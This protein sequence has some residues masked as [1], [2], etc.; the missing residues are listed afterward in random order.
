MHGRYIADSGQIVL[1]AGVLKLERTAPWSCLANLQ[2]A[3]RDISN[4]NVLFTNVL[5]SPYTGYEI[6]IA[7]SGIVRVK[8]MHEFFA[9]QTYIEVDGAIFV[10]DGNPHMVAA[11]YDGSSTAAGVKIYVDG[12]PDTVVTVNKDTLNSTIVTG[13]SDM[14]LCNQSG[15]QWGLGILNFF[16][17]SNVVR[18]AAYMAAHGSLATKPTTDANTTLYYSFS[19]GTGTTLTDQSSNN[20]TGTVTN[21]VWT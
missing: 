17:F 15:N 21:G 5:N 19:E 7:P 13:A 10:A 14:W 6:W 16:A 18:N 1:P 2:I 3:N 11:T 9:S 4:G 12:V 8:I 20:Y